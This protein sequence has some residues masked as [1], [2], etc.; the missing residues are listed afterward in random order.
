MQLQTDKPK[1]PYHKWK[2]KLIAI[3]VKET[4]LEKSKIKINDEGAFQWW[5]DGFTPYVTFRETFNSVT[6]YID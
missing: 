3:T 6:P 5:H 4:G 2:A 1:L